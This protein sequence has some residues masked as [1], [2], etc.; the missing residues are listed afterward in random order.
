[1]SLQN[2]VVKSNS[3]YILVENKTSIHLVTKLFYKDTLKELSKS[4][5]VQIRR[6]LGSGNAPGPG[7][8]HQRTNV[9][10]F[11][12]IESGCCS[13]PILSLIL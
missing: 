12:G 6:W 13:R 2:G 3:I 7:P 11:S 4:L 1:M 10:K 9:V 5:F 8:K